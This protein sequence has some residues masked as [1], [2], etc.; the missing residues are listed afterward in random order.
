MTDPAHSEDTWL[1]LRIHSPATNH[2]N[3]LIH[4][5]IN[6]FIDCFNKKFIKH[7]FYVPD[8]HCAGCQ[9]LMA[10]RVT[11]PF[12]I[13]MPQVPEIPWA[14][15]LHVAINLAQGQWG[16]WFHQKVLIIPHVREMLSRNQR[17]DVLNLNSFCCLKNY[18]VRVASFWPSEKSFFM[19]I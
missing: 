10:I 17:H 4:S 11:S 12:N 3:E 2:T 8:T 1:G 16:T 13:N 5:F 14:K 9:I 7:K 15:Q 6:S 19:K 18:R